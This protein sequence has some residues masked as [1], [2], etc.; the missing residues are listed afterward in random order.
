MDARQYIRAALTAAR[1]Y[2]GRQVRLAA[3]GVTV[4]DSLGVRHDL[5]SE[6][7]SPSQE[8]LVQ[9]LKN[10]HSFYRDHLP[11]EVEIAGHG[12]W[13]CSEIDGGL[14]LKSKRPRGACL[15]AVASL[16]VQA[17]ATVRRLYAASGVDVVVVVEGEPRSRDVALALASELNLSGHPSGLDLPPERDRRIPE[18]ET[19]ADQEGP[20]IFDQPGP[21]PWSV[22]LMPRNSH[23]GSARIVAPDMSRVIVINDDRVRW[24]YSQA[25]PET[26]KS[27]TRPTVLVAISLEKSSPK[28]KIVLSESAAALAATLDDHPAGPW[29]QYNARKAKS[30]AIP[31][32]PKTWHQ[33]TEAVAEAYLER[34]APRGYVSGQSVFFHGPVAFSIYYNNP[35][36]A[37]VDSPTGPLIFMGRSYVRG[38]TKGGT[39]S[40]AQGDVS[41]AAAAAGVPVVHVDRLTD[42]L[43]L[44]GLQLD[45]IAR[46]FEHRKN[47]TAFSAT[48]T[49]DPVRLGD[50]LT[51]CKA[52][53]E[54]ELEQASKHR[55]PTLRRAAAWNGLKLLAER[56]DQLADVF[57]LALP[58]MGDAAHFDARH[59]EAY[60]AARDWQKMSHEERALAALAAPPA[61]EEDADEIEPYAPGL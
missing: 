21:K 61:A 43:T 23:L 17:M 35:I 45:G 53:A 4:V 58:D 28:A 42:F 38:G 3:D 54:L 29:T 31:R 60:E 47:E 26:L 20:S 37:I 39:I 55:S 51:S 10:P 11:E 12:V 41:R 24:S 13:T 40:M 50:Y 52:A 5:A 16:D 2:A 59:S 9:G 7:P 34:K 8:D 25:T 49:L 18:E 56:R 33:T 46:D 36:A 44:D 15:E 57:G 32:A 48:C 30:S 19:R 14:V 22:Q 27:Q 1:T 6:V